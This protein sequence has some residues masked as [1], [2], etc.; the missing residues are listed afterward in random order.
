MHKSSIVEMVKFRNNYMCR[1]RYYE[2]LDIGSCD[3]N[4]SY[5]DVLCEYP[6][7]VYR[8]L[9]I[10]SGPNVDLVIAERNWGNPHYKADVVVS[11]QC[12]EHVKDLSHWVEQIPK[13]LRNDG[14]GLVCLIA[15]WKFKEHRHPVDCWRIL[16]DGMRW[17]LEEV[18]GLDVISV[19]KSDINTVGIGRKK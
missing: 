3:V 8:G 17:L 15:P 16:P 11:G 19:Y 6:H 18:A 13:C 7:V 10:V 5:R 1:D 14:P 4:G 9:D 12:M 2:V